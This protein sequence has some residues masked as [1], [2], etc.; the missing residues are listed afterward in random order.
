MSISRREGGRTQTAAQVK[1][2]GPRYLENPSHGGGRRAVKDPPP[3]V[4][5]L[6]RSAASLTSYPPP[7]P[8]SAANAQP[9]R[10]PSPEQP[11]PGATRSPQACLSSPANYP[12][13]PSPAKA[14][15]PRRAT[16]SL[17][18]GAGEAARA[19]LQAPAGAA[20]GQ[21]MRDAPGAR[22]P[23]P[24]DGPSR[25]GP[26]PARL[27]RDSLPGRPAPAPPPHR[28]GARV[29]RYFVTS[30]PLAPSPRP[31]PPRRRPPPMA[32][33]PGCQLT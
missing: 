2:S 19:A 16:L 9:S 14:L 26:P 18:R 15:P 23:R 27:P 7:G 11:L 20:G 17:S 6:P 24:P 28:Y 32:S 29:E 21:A 5:I 10:P 33:A 22:L 31:A 4:F 1:P 12:A 30:F 8:S 13:L 25:T 3:A